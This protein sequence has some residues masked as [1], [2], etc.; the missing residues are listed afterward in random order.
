MTTNFLFLSGI[1]LNRSDKHEFY[2]EQDVSFPNFICI[3]IYRLYYKLEA[4]TLKLQDL[5]SF[6][7]QLNLLMLA[8]LSVAN[9]IAPLT[10]YFYLF[11]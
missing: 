3:L 11:A 8:F 2:I 7:I 6:P 1:E 4:R 9:I 5:A 10:P